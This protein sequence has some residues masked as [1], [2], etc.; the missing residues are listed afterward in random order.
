M[1]RHH[2]ADRQIRRRSDLYEIRM[3]FNRLHLTFL[4]RQKNGLNLVILNAP[5]LGI[6]LPEGRIVL[7]DIDAVSA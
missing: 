4:P 5:N 6:P 7:A 3:F 2:L 1:M